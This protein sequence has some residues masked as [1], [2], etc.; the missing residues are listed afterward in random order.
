LKR[1]GVAAVY[2]PKDFV[3]NAI[4]ADIVGHVERAFDKGA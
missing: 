2:T 3:V 4:I 1:D